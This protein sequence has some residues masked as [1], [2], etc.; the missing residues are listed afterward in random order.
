MPESVNDCTFY[1]DRANSLYS[2]LSDFVHKNVKVHNLDD[3][4]FLFDEVRLAEVLKPFD[5]VVR[6]V[7]FPFCV[8]YL[9]TLNRDQ[10][11]QLSPAIDA[12]AG[13]VKAFQKLIG[14][15]AE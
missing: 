3:V 7:T 2:R 10:I 12:L 13:D 5:E 9:G 6:V 15:Q 4:S 8:R 1:A 14:G 11:E